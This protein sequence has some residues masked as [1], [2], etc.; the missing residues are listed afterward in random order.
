MI[1]VKTT[2]VHGGQSLAYFDYDA[3]CPYFY[4]EGHG[5][6]RVNPNPKKKGIYAWCKRADENPFKHEKEEEGKVHLF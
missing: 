2:C 4:G 3:L 5:W 1:F 6:L